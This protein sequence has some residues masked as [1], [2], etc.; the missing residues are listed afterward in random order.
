[1]KI[2]LLQLGAD[3]GVAPVDPRGT[4]V[5]VHDGVADV[6][7]GWLYG[8]VANDPSRVHVNESTFLAPD[9]LAAPT[10]T[11]TADSMMT[12]NRKGKLKISVI[13]GPVGSYEVWIDGVLVGTMS[14]NPAGN[15]SAEFRS[16]P[17]RG[18]GNANRPGKPGKVKLPMGFDPRLALIELKQLG[19]TVFSGEMAAQIGGLNVC[20]P[21]AAPAPLALAPGQ[22][23]GAGTVTFGQD[24]DCSRTLALAVSGLAPGT[25]DVV[26]GGVPVAALAVAPDGTGAV[27]FDS[28]PDALGELP[29]DFSLASGTGIA[30]ELAGVEVLVATVP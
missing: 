17:P 22:V 8:P 9:A 30:V 12:P 27:A 10:G 7:G 4:F 21:F 6:L 11:A 19:A 25:Y 28:S 14:S 13:G 23:A 29:L 26:V 3:L 5:T 18:N 15:A 1:V 16:D 24:D 2:D 20:L